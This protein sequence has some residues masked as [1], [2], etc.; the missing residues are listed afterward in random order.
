MIFNTLVLRTIIIQPYCPQH[1]ARPVKKNVTKRHLNIR[2]TPFIHLRLHLVHI[3]DFLFG[4][5]H[6]IAHFQSDH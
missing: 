1:N 4:L 2:L 5:E 6:R 3:V